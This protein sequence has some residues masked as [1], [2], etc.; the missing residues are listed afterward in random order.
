MAAE[1]DLNQ[2][3]APIAPD[4]SSGRDLRYERS[5]EALL[6]SADPTPVETPLPNGGKTMS[7]PQRDF[8]KIRR[9]ALDLL[10]IGRDLRALVVFAEALA[11]T[12][13][14]AGLAA[15]L[16]LIRRSLQEH[17]HTLHPSLD[18]DETKPADQAAL[19]L[20]ALRSLAAPDDMLPEL[21]R[22]RLLEVAGLGGVSLRDWEL[23]S[24]RGSPFA[25]ET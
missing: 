18:L 7:P 3:L 6:E 1:I 4:A 13:G 20:N 24:G 12:D 17:W 16:T 25:Y 14:P 22:I 11:V 9:D 21:G 23:A 8:K 5:F 2:L 15:G 10:R 19:R